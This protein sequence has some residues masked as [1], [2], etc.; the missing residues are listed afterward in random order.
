MHIVLTANRIL[1]IITHF[2]IGKSIVLS[3]SSLPFP[4][5]RHNWVPVMQVCQRCNIRRCRLHKQICSSQ[6]ERCR[7][8]TP[9]CTLANVHD[10]YKICIDNG[11]VKYRK[12]DFNT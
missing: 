4:R 7:N 2:S 12:G 1:F 11:N 10:I 5:K 9:T 8:I 3:D 6:C